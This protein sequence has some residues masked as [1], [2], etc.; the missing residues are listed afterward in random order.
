MREHRTSDSIVQRLAS[1]IGTMSEN[2]KAGWS[3]QHAA[4]YSSCHAQVDALTLSSWK[5]AFNDAFLG[6]AS[7]LPACIGVICEPVHAAAA[8]CRPSCHLF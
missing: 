7:T 6:A 3:S 2:G 5:L 1:A 4:F 8:D